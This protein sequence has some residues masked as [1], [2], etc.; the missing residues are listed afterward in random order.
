MAYLLPVEQHLAVHDHPPGVVHAMREARA[1]NDYIDAALNL[2]EHQAAHRRQ[3][4]LVFPVN[5][6][7]PR[8]CVFIDSFRQFCPFV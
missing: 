8:F 1:E 7:S 4:F 2:G 3:V 5:L 6:L